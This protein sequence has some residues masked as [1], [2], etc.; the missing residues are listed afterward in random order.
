MNIHEFVHSPH[1]FLAGMTPA[2]LRLLGASATETHFAAGDIIF[3]EGDAA[4]RF[5][6]LQRGEIALQTHSA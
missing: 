4:D 1:P 3:R 6:L 5:Y 2:H